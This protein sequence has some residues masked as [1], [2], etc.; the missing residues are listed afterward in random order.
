[1]SR[2]RNLK[3]RLWPLLL[4]WAAVVPWFFYSYFVGENSVRE[5]Q[6]LKNTKRELK[7]E[8]NYWQFQNEI[9]KEKLAALKE[10]SKFYYEKLSREMLVKGKEGEEVILFVK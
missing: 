1:L 9:L 4:L 3:C 5:L 2:K 6:K 10:N 7:K 8:A